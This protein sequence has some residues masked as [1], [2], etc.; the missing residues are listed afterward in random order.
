MMST[1]WPL[2]SYRRQ[3]SK[4]CFGD[5]WKKKVEKEQQIMQHAASNPFEKP[6]PF[7]G[8]IAPSE[9]FTR[10]STCFC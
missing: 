1:I 9:A 7:A 3:S 8:S 10:A 2:G 5:A 6:E 4:N